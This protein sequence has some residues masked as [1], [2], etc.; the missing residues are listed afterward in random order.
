M[1]AP[2]ISGRNLRRSFYGAKINVAARVFCILFGH[3][4]AAK[5]GE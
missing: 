4:R 3:A 2:I 5:Q 1:I